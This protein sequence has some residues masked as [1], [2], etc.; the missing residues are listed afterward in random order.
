MIFQA[1][2]DLKDQM[3]ASLSSFCI[4]IPAARSV[5][6]V[7]YLIDSRELWVGT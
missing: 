7:E 6:Y 1:L 3:D 4:S 2:V 5:L